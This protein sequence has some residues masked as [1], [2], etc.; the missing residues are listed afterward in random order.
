MPAKRQGEASGHDKFRWCRT[1]SDSR[2]A[3]IAETHKSAENERVARPERQRSTR[4][5]SLELEY[6]EIMV[7]VNVNF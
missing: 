5:I 2:H 4:S 3:V 6:S 1:R 7:T